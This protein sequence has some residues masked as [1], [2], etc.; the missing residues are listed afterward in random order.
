MRIEL[1]AARNPAQAGS[2]GGAA[3]AGMDP[4]TSFDADIPGP[5]AASID[6]LRE[7]HNEAVRRLD[8]CIKEYD[9]LHDAVN[10]R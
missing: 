8:A 9:G 1:T 10:A 4:G 5:I 6:A 3:P 2:T 7:A